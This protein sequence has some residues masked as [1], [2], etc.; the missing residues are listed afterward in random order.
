MTA[1]ER[2]NKFPYCY[3]NDYIQNPIFHKT[4]N[5]LEETK[6]PIGSTALGMIQD[7]CDELYSN[8]ELRAMDKMLGYCLYKRDADVIRMLIDYICL[9]DEYKKELGKSDHEIVIGFFKA[10]KIPVRIIN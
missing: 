1:M 9:E 3:K 5:L 6:E 8:K 2:I 7:L 10:H 4:V